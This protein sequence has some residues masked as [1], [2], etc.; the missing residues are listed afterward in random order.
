MRNLIER[1]RELFGDKSLVRPQLID[2]KR[3]KNFYSETAI[4][5]RFAYIN[6]RATKFDK[7]SLSDA[8]VTPEKYKAIT[9]R[10]NAYYENNGVALEDWPYTERMNKITLLI[11]AD[12][13]V[14]LEHWHIWHLLLHMRKY[15]IL[16]TY[17]FDSGKT[18]KMIKQNRR[19]AAKRN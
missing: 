5:R 10:L 15:G 18:K 7:I 19:R 1:Q 9:E 14:Y 3:L 4:A 6:L 12:F 17:S 16:A 11:N 8:G 2:K 13:K